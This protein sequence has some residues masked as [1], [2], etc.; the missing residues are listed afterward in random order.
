LSEFGK[1]LKASNA[2]PFARAAVLLWLVAHA[3]LVT[4]T[5]QHNEAGFE[6]LATCGIEASPGN[7]SNGPLGTRRDTCCMSCCLQRN[8]VNSINPISIPPDLCLETVTPE[9]FALESSSNGVILVLSNRAPPI[10]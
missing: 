1:F 6:R 9:A 8:F 10:A 5:H 4:V 7:S 2:G 3:S